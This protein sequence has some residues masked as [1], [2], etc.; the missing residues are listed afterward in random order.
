MA[1]P[2]GFPPQKGNPMGN[3][4]SGVLYSFGTTLNHLELSCETDEE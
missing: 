4:F 2:I 1:F 3:A